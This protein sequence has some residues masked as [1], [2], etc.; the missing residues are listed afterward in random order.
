MITRTIGRPRNTSEIL[1]SGDNNLNSRRIKA[2]MI[3]ENLDLGK[4]TN[5]TG[6]H[7]TNVSKFI[8][9][10]G[11]DKKLITLFEHLAEKHPDVFNSIR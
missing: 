1:F 10:N 6:V 3:A 7:Y 4:I 9:G 5:I 8:N 2:L 11:S